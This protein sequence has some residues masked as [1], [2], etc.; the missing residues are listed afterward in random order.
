MGGVVGPGQS[1]GG[2]IDA[3]GS[4]G[5]A[6]FVWIV[7]GGTSGSRGRWTQ[8]GQ[9]G[10]I[11]LADLLQNG[12]EIASGGARQVVVEDLASGRCVV[13]R[14]AFVPHGGRVISRV[15]DLDREL[16]S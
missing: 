6:D 4:V 9:A 16:S 5:I 1:R 14:I 10:S 12:W 7:G 3:L 15:F 2:R 13:G 8:T 11:T